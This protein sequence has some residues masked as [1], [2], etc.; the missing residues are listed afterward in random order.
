[1][2]MC[3]CIFSGFK[4]HIIRE[5]ESETEDLP[6]IVIELCHDSRG[7]VGQMGA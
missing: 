3:D 4:A 2:Q 1:M 6:C 5:E 7:S